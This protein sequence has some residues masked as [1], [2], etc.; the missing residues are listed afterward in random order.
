MDSETA[1]ASSLPEPSPSGKLSDVAPPPS[2]VSAKE[3]G[4]FAN[5]IVNAYLNAVKAVQVRTQHIISQNKRRYQEEGFDLDMIYIT[6][7]IIAMGFPA[8]DL[9]SGLFGYF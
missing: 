7:N 2:V 4:T 9:S 6:E 5:G 8:G 1:H 3:I